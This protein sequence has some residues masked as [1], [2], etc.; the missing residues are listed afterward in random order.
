[1]TEG[2]APD[3][4]QMPESIQSEAKV[5][6]SA[7]N[8][9]VLASVIPAAPAAAAVTAGS[10][11]IEPEMQ[12]APIGGKTSRTAEGKAP[13]SMQASGRIQREAKVPG[14]TMN[15]EIKASAI[16]TAAAAA[17]VTA[18]SGRIEPE[19]QIAPA[20]GK[21]DGIGKSRPVPSGSGKTPA[22]GTQIRQAPEGG[23]LM[24]G[25]TTL[26]ADTVQN[27]IPFSG[28]AGMKNGAEEQTKKPIV[29]GNGPVVSGPAGDRHRLPYN[30]TPTA[31]PIGQRADS[32]RRTPGTS[33]IPQTPIGPAPAGTGGN[34]TG[35]WKETTTG[36]PTLPAE[37][38]K[39]VPN[40]GEKGIYPHK[41]PIS[42]TSCGKQEPMAP[43]PGSTGTVSPAPV[44]A[45]NQTEKTGTG[46]CTSETQRHESVHQSRTGG[47]SAG[48]KGAPVSGIPGK[49]GAAGENHGS[50]RTEVRKERTVEK[51]AAPNTTSNIPTA[52]EN[53]TNR[54]AA[55]HGEAKRPL[56][57]PAPTAPQGSVS[58]TTVVQQMPGASGGVPGRDRPAGNRKDRREKNRHKK[59]N[60]NPQMSGTGVCPDM[61]HRS[62]VPRRK[63]HT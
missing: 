27:S 5:S 58:R 56:T 13:D 21:P 30:E 36:K 55:P 57:A 31:S 6:G 45:G 49:P 19:M 7:M 1:M 47:N 60:L 15:Q 11:R 48:T 53:R 42:S 25:R 10:G 44:S 50:G 59:P 4:R 37:A 54:P 3:S 22:E 16:P 39:T 34:S 9:S 63:D 18:G 17:A 23:R 46:R 24:P 38:S 62:G 28:R 8:Q 14:S 35:M 29:E 41:S 33:K 12:T 43:Y 52:V 61:T 51:N 40:A 2:N 20:G 32:A 26:A